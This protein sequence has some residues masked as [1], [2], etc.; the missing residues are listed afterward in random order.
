[1]VIR[2]ILER[3]MLA[4]CVHGDCIQSTGKLILR[5]SSQPSM[6]S[7]QLCTYTRY[8]KLLIL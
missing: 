2:G 7:N 3:E 1:M 5:L 8:F 6:L 4:L